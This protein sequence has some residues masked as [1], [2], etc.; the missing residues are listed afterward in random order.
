MIS[1]RTQARF[2]ELEKSIEAWGDGRWLV[3]SH[4]NPDP[5]ALVSMA[6]LGQILKRRFHR[7]VTIAYGGIIGRAENQE[8]CRSL[9]YHFSRLRH[10]K[11]NS[12]RHFALVDSQPGTGN[13]QLPPDLSVRLVL[14]HHPVRKGARQAAFSDIRPDYGATASI[15]A[16]YLLSSGLPITKAAATG[17]VCAI[18]S[19]TLS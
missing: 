2:R 13:N 10:I 15:A 8:M 14:D 7:K 6:I 19:E 12:Y 17:L 16:E 9:G 5:D 1:Q 4:D 18:H 11:W 3:M